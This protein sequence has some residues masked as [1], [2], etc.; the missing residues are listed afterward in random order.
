M[1]LY[2]FLFIISKYNFLAFGTDLIYEFKQGKEPSVRT[3]Y[4]R[5]GSQ[6]QFPCFI[7]HQ[8][9]QNYGKLIVLLQNAIWKGP[10]GNMMMPGLI[11]SNRIH[12][13]TMKTI[14]VRFEYI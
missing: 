13:D 11:E 12:I 10:R 1:K 7:M 2:Y 3:I 5:A 14:R 9:D 8:T 4:A 6:I